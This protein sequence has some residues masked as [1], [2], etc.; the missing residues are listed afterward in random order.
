MSSRARTL[1]GL[2]AVLGLLAVVVLMVK[3][4]HASFDDD[5]ILRLQAFDRPVGALPTEVDCGSVLSSV[6]STDAPATLYTIARDQACHDE[7]YRRLMAA[8]ASACVVVILSLLLFVGARV[9]AGEQVAGP[10]TRRR[11]YEA[12]RATWAAGPATS[13][14]ASSSADGQVA[15][16][17]EKGAAEEPGELSPADEAR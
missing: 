1:C 7:G 2:V 15:H 3:P 16:D 5:P 8:I 4:V 13:T 9:A 14:S 11:R 12:T 10:R 17:T 6:R